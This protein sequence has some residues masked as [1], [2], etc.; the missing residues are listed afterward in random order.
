M[1]R[2][3]IGI[4]MGDPVG[5]GPEIVLKALQ[6]KKRYEICKPMVIGSLAVLRKVERI[7]ATG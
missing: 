7:I 6:S 2:P 3:V 1:T 4:P 5:I